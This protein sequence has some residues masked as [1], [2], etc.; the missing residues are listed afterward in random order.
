MN[1]I[2]NRVCEVDGDGFYGVCTPQKVLLMK[3]I[4]TG[5][6]IGSFITYLPSLCFFAAPFPQINQAL[7]LK[8]RIQ[9]HIHGSL[10]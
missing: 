6:E 8:G 4:V 7:I 9:L 5:Q 2:T 10:M 1:N 3:I